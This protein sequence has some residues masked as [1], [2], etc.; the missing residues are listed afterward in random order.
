MNIF[1]HFGNADPPNNPPADFH[2]QSAAVGISFGIFRQRRVAERREIK[3]QLSEAATELPALCAI[4]QR[5]GEATLSTWSLLFSALN[6]LTS[7]E[8][9]VNKR[10]QNIHAR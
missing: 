10:A 5:N 2:K 1:I 8:W 9:I 4:E 7:G 6:Q 3:N